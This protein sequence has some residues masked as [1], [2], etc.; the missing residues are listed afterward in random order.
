MGKVPRLCLKNG[1]EFPTIPQELLNLTTLEERL[2]ALRLPFIQIRALGIDKQCGMKGNVVHIMNS[3]QETT[4]I[5]PRRFDVTSTIQVQL[6][7]HMAHE[8]P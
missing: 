6:M 2:V 1:L 5:L 4:Q 8:K 7:R 3:L